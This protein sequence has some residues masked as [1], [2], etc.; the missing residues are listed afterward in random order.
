MSAPDG[1]P[2]LTFQHLADTL[3]VLTAAP[4]PTTQS[5]TRDMLTLHGQYKT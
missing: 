5:E 4:I 2:A 3:P 1:P